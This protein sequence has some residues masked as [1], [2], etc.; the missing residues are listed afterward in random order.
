MSRWQMVTLNAVALGARS[1]VTVSG[2]IQVTF[3]EEGKI[4]EVREGR[5][6]WRDYNIF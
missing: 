2:M 5:K 6:V 4:T 1:E 3:G